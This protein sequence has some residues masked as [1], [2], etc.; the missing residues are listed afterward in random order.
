VSAYLLPH[1]QDRPLV[2]VRYPDGIKGKHFYQKECS[3]YAPQWVPT[4]SIEHS[5]DKRVN[6]CLCNDLQTLL[7]L[8]NQ[9][10]IE[11]HPWLSRYNNLNNPDY[12]VFDLDPAPLSPFKEVIFLAL[13]FKEVLKEF[14]LQG[15]LKTSGASG[16][17]I[18]VPISAKHPYPLITKAA[19][20]M[21]NIV[22]EA[23]PKQATVERLLKN[24]KDRIYLD[25]LQNGRGKTIVSVYC[26]RPQPKAPVSIPITW[27]EIS[28]HGAVNDFS[29]AKFNIKT[30]LIRLEKT[31]DLF[32]QVLSLKQ[33]LDGLL[34]TIAN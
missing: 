17:H 14:G 22:A 31:G 18:Y 33:N 10:S 16:L 27:E 13:R 28:Q 25:Y 21:A 1:L 2:L 7:W 9:G 30:T 26:L 15:F 12:M 19:R 32:A 24:R 3:K 5:G 29:P 23:Y 4:V 20:F 34:R 6:Y 11:I 8:I